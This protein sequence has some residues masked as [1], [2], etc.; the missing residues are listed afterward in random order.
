MSDSGNITEPD[1]QVPAELLQLALPVS[2]KVVL[3]ID[4]VESVRLM[5]ADEA[6]T[7][8][9]WHAF[10]QT[11]QKQIFPKHCGRLVKSL[12]DG[13][14]VEFDDPRLAVQAAFSL[15]A[16]AQSR[17]VGHAPDRH[18]A[19]RA[20][21]HATHVYQGGNDIYGA[22]V[23][24]AARIATLANPGETVATAEVRDGITDGLDAEVEDQG[25]SFV[26]HLAMPVRTYRMRDPQQTVSRPV[27]GAPV[28]SLLP[29]IAVIPFSSRNLGNGHFAI[30][31]LLAE[32]V[33][34][35]L[36]RNA[37][38]RVISYLSSSR[39]RGRLS[40]LA[41]AQQHMG[42]EYIL[43]GSFATDG[44]N[45]SVT[46]EL[47]NVRE[48]TVL[49]A[50]QRR[51]AVSDLL[52]PDSQAIQALSQGVREALLRHE[53]ERAISLPLPSLESCSL[54][55]GAITLMHRMSRTDFERAKLMLDHLIERHPRVAMPR[56][57]LA[58]WHSLNVA[59]SW[60]TDP[61][62]DTRLANSVIQAA[63]NID[64]NNALALSVKGIVQGYVQKQFGEALNSYEMALAANP[65]EPLAWIGMATLNT[66]S[67]HLTEAMH[68]AESALALSPI[69]PMKYYFDSLASTA[70]LAGGNYEQAILLAHRSLRANRLFSSTGKTLVL[71]LVMVGRLDDAREQADKLLKLEPG[72]SVTG[73]R[74]K[75]PMYRSAR[76]EEFAVA[77]ESAGIP[78]H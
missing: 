62:L 17:N 52:D 9:R 54:L 27:S 77:Y 45:I 25:E 34:A 31:E 51:V 22:G 76:G 64:S 26:K 78:I 19:L 8:A 74:H 7:V 29:T 5:A 73:F 6:G 72:F 15:H 71:A 66:W 42:A 28:T 10:S 57:W 13:L 43:A 20:G 75:S 3:V 37:D 12:G 24:L 32:G 67:G 61:Q 1:N 18:M 16:L 40:A 53:V 50:L 30:G 39:L 44:Q 56:A 63:L 59:Q 49:T 58:K 65:N 11:A 23:N 48:Q 46:A 41:I 35:R 69:D 2:Q 38:L 47:S 70:M 60:S 68:C 36:S 55:F 4:L 14:M 21:V 33:I